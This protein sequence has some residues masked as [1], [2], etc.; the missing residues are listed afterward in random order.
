MKI[1]WLEKQSEIRTSRFH[2]I[3]LFQKKGQ[4]HPKKKNCQNFYN[5]ILM[6]NIWIYGNNI[7]DCFGKLIGEIVKQG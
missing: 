3:N 5:R 1:I 2:I 6:E 4:N 7:L